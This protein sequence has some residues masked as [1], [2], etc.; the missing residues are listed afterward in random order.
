M[1][2]ILRR[3]KHQKGYQKHLRRLANN[4]CDFCEFSNKS[5]QVVKAYKH[6][7]IVRNIFSYD[8]WDSHSVKRHLMIVPKRHVRDLGEFLSNET[9]E[10]MKLVTLYEKQGF[11]SFTRSYRTKARS[12]AH[13]HT[14]LIKTG[15]KPLKFMVYIRK[16]HF[17][18][19]K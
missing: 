2:N 19:H 7:W 11:S 3:R 6:F 16:P 9:V 13:A 18:F 1:G 5:K 15:V 17:L 10:Y 14:H 4:Q 12:I 8:I